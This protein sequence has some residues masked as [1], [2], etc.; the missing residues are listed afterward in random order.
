ME[1]KDFIAHVRKNDDEAWAV[2]HF[3]SEHLEGTAKLAEAF[4]A[5]FDSGEWGRAAGIAHDAGKGR[6]EW[7]NYLRQK[8]GFFDEEAH[9][10]GKYGKI[11]HAIHGAKLVEEVFGKSIGRVLAYSIAG[12]HAGLPDY[13]NAEGAGQSSLQFQLKQVKDINK[14]DP[15][16]KN[17]ILSATPPSLPRRFSSGIDLSLWIRMLYSCLV[18]A[19]FLD[20]EHYM[21]L[22]QASM[23]SC[24]CTVEEMLQRFNAFINNLEKT[25]ADTPVNRIRRNI[26]EKCVQMGK[27]DMGIFSL[28]VPTGGGKTLSS[29]AF[30]LEHAKKHNLERII[31]VIP[32]TS[33]IEQNAN[34]IRSALG[35]DQVIEHHSSIDEDE[36]S[37]KSRLASEN[38]DAPI[39][40]TTS[41]QFYESLFAAKSSRCRKLHNIVNSVV[42]LDVA[43]LIPI[44]YL[45]P[46]LVTIQ[47][48]A[49]HYLVS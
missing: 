32:Y 10:E 24:C 8:S 19:D 4:A 49:V 34:V 14:I 23:R 9:L 41:V 38:W 3:L 17:R 27:E 2:P 1:E 6:L 37:V 28:T 45:N 48:L 31:Y 36:S 7:Q 16:I 15:S 40:V 21:N 35:D 13:S 42:I 43:Q 44:V 5:K 11:P 30:A 39:V 26:K 22:D 12:H 25:S 33:I 29:L 18:D 46:I 47:L 20:T